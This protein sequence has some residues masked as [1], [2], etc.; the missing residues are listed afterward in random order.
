MSTTIHITEAQYIDPRAGN[1]KFY[2]TY[3]LGSTWVT[4]Y[5]R[6]GTIGTFTKLIEVA[7]ED[8]A[9]KAAAPWCW[10]RSPQVPRR[11]L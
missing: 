11:R 3:V 5:G 8:A 9:A 7:S 6:N 4:Q 2:R 10:H 1:D